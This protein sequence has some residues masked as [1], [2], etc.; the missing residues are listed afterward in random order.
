MHLSIAHWKGRGR[1]PI[2]DHY[3]SSLGPTVEMLQVLMSQNRNF[4]KG[5]GSL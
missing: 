2:H 1:L 4:P 5:C 3:T